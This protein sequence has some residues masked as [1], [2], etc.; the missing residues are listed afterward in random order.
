MKVVL[1]IRVPG[2]LKDEFVKLAEARGFTNAEML[3]YLVQLYTDHYPNG[4]IQVSPQTPHPSD[5][6]MNEVSDLVV[7]GSPNVGNP[8]MGDLPNVGDT[9]IGGDP[10]VKRSGTSTRAPRKSSREKKITQAAKFSTEAF[11]LAQAFYDKLDE[12]VAL[13][14]KRGWYMEQVGIAESMFK[15]KMITLQQALECLSWALADPW[16]GIHLTS[17]AQFP[18]VLSVYQRQLVAQERA[19]KWMNDLMEWVDERNKEG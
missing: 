9:L 15:T 2:V 5:N 1:S 19:P 18:K 17:L 13:P 12:A 3:E 4:S 8:L 16:W 11:A 14:P 7:S 10:H 6:T